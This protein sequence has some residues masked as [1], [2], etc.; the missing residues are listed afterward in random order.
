MVFQLNI[1]NQIFPLAITKTIRNLEKIAN[2]RLAYT[3]LTI[4]RFLDKYFVK[5]SSQ[6]PNLVTV[7]YFEFSR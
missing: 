1:S 4:T 7:M 3:F 2:I 5:F 6:M